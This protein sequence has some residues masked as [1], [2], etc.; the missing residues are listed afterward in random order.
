MSFDFGAATDEVLVGD[1]DADGVDTLMLH[2][3]NRFFASNDFTGGAAAIEFTLGNG[4][5]TAYAARLK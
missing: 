3:G 5:E 1:W 2:R 4:S